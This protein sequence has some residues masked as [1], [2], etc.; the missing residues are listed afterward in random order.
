MTAPLRAIPGENGLPV[1]GHTLQFIRNCNSLF[2][3]MHGKYGPVYFNRYLS[4]RACLLYTS[5]AADDC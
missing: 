1:V 5:D 4:T 3:E 2:Q